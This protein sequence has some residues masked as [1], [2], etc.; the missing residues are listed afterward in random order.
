MILGTDIK[1]SQVAS[2]YEHLGRT[3][4]QIVEAHAHLGLAEVHAA[5]AYFYE[6]RDAIRAEWRAAD[7]LIVNVQRRFPGRLAK[8]HATP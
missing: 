8:R 5:L 7:D 2:E 6:N 1:V 3:P 4:D